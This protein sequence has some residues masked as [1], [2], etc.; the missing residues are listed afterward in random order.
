MKMI[1]L[2]IIKPTIKLATASHKT[3]LLSNKNLYLK[4]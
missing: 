1:L 3:N 4:L 2:K